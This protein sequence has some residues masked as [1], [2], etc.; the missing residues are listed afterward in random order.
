MEQKGTED[1]VVPEVAA[2][3]SNLTHFPDG[4]VIRN[5]LGQLQARSATYQAALQEVQSRNLQARDDDSLA[6]PFGWTD[7]AQSVLGDQVKA[8]VFVTDVGGDGEN[9][10]GIM[11]YVAQGID[12]NGRLVR[13]EYAELVEMPVAGVADPSDLKTVALFQDG[14]KVAGDIEERSLLSRFTKCIR[15]GCSS[16]CL[17]SITACAGVF[18]VYLKCVIVKCGGCAVKCGACAAC[19]CSFWCKW[20]TG[21]CKN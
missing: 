12:E 9:N 8:S 1:S 7:V 2:I 21:C 6:E 5:E 19:N 16:A 20:A 17:G 10:L 11:V 14:A 13:E 18:P 3:A 4:G 15:N